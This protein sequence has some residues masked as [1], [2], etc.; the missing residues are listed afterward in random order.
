M[1]GNKS[2]RKSP[3]RLLAS[4]AVVAGSVVGAWFVIESSKITEVYLV[5]RS[6]LASGTALTEQSL[7]TT[8]LALFLWELST[9]R[10]AS[11]PRGP[12]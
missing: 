2:A 5:T 7:E 1:F 12:I 10:K 9:C 11:F 4:A 8:D 6:D 3:V